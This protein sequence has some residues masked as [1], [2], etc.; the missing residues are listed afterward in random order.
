[1][2]GVLIPDSATRLKTWIP[3]ETS[4]WPCELSQAS[5]EALGTAAHTVMA[6]YK[7]EPPLLDELEELVA[8]AS[9][10]SPESSKIVRA[11]REAFTAVK[12]DFNQEIEKQWSEVRPVAGFD[13]PACR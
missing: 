4:F 7:D 10:T 3:V 2:L 9:E 1:M 8:V 13:A 5:E 11:V 12:Q 6:G